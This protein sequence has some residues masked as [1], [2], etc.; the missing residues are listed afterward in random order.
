MSF[1]VMFPCKSAIVLLDLLYNTE[2]ASCADCSDSCRREG[3]VNFLNGE[4]LTFARSSSLCCQNALNSFKYN[5]LCVR[6]SSIHL[7]NIY[8]STHTQIWR[9]TVSGVIS[10]SLKKTDSRYLKIFRQVQYSLLHSPNSYWFTYVP[11]HTLLF[12]MQKRQ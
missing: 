8:V 12:S 10:L 4:V 9:C 7:L 2:T 11:I 3:K 5:W 1:S 6:L